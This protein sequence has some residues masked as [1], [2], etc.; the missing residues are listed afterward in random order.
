MDNGCDSAVIVA[1]E[2][3]KGRGET[4]ELDP[5]PDTGLERRRKHHD[6]FDKLLHVEVEGVNDGTSR[7]VVVV[8]NGYSGKTASDRPLLKHVYL[9]L[10]AKVLPQ[11]MGCGTASYP[12]PDHRWS[13]EDRSQ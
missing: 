13:T 1:G 9:D 12:R 5:R 2:L 4:L 10:R 6:L 7:L 8:I 3:L 11:E